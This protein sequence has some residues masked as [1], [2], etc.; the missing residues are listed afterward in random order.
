MYLVLKGSSAV[1]AKVAVLAFFQSYPKSD[2][3]K[4]GQFYTCP[5]GKMNSA[6]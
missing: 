5:E 6:T 2:V 1:G 3:V 4:L